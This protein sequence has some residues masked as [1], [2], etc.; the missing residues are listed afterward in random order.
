MHIEAMVNHTHTH[1]DRHRQDT[2]SATVQDAA[3]NYTL[4]CAL[5]ANIEAMAKHKHT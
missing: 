5:W 1:T 3:H 2:D 4:I